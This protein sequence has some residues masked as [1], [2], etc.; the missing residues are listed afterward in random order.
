MNTNTGV[1]EIFNTATGKRYIGS[2]SKLDARFKRHRSELR[3]G[4]HHSPKLQRAWDKYG[5]GAF[6][7]L[8]ILTCQKSML[9]FYEQQLLDKAKPEYNIAG[10]AGAPMA[11]RKHTERTR[12]KLSVAGAGRPHT[13]EHSAAIAVAIK[14]SPVARAQLAQLHQAK[15]GAPVSPNTRAKISAAHTGKPLSAAHRKAISDGYTPREYILPSAIT[16][17]RMS[18]AQKGNSNRLGK[19]TSPETKALLSALALARNAKKR[20]QTS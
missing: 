18:V 13:A 16:K 4:T 3:R 8:P 7:F 17:A 19:P 9:L 5:E 20:Q 10:V 11:G 6:K 1:Y 15:K 14:T 12:A 2:A